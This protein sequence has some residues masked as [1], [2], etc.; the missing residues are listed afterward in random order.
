MNKTNKNRN[1]LREM[2]AWIANNTNISIEEMNCHIESALENDRI[3]T[4]LHD[5]LGQSWYMMCLWESAGNDQEC[6]E[7]LGQQIAWMAKRIQELTEDLAPNAAPPA[8]EL[9]KDL[10][11]HA[12]GGRVKLVGGARVAMEQKT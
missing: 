3:T 10:E 7:K 2:R 6:L 9:R 5:L 4:R 1:T 11:A 12:C 8:K